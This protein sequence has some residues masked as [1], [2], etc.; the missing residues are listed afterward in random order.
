[1][2]ESKTEDPKVMQLANTLKSRGLA[3]SMYDAIERAR[4]ILEIRPMKI[5]VQSE[6]N[7]VQNDVT[8]NELMREV[9]VSPEQVE[10]QEKQRLESIKDE[11]NNIRVDIE[12]AK[13][14]PEKPNLIKEEIDKVEGE[15]INLTEDAPESKAEKEPHKAKHGDLAEEEEEY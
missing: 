2:D 12:V 11:L 9:G 5:D 15:V 13:R 14:A 1:M 4:N 7:D 8:L 10:A 6:G 3:V